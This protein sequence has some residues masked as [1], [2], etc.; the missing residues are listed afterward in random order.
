M[1]VSTVSW[2]RPFTYLDGRWRASLESPF[3]LEVHSTWYG[4]EKFRKG[5]AAPAKV[6]T[7]LGRRTAG[8]LGALPKYMPLVARGFAT[9]WNS[10][11]RGKRKAVTA[12]AMR[13]ELTPTLLLFNAG[14]GHPQYMLWFE[15]IARFG[16]YLPMISVTGTRPE[17]VALESPLDAKH[18][19]TLPSL[20]SERC[21]FEF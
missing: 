21:C 20:P 16:K 9:L 15:P 2:L 12:A 3:A 4:Q 1:L 13:A 19:P 14:E 18:R 11:W 17:A 10:G 7:K 5:S 6:E 8:V